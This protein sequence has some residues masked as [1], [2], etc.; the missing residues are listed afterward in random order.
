MIWNEIKSNNDIQQL[1]QIY[2]YFE[3]SM[4]V[5]MEYISG[6]HI[7]SERVGHMDQRNDLKAVFQRLSDE[8]IVNGFNDKDSI[9]TVNYALSTT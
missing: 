6:D 1:N 2:N 7:D 3:D 5:H 8:F 9:L 4:L